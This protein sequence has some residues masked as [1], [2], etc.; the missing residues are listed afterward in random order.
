MHELSIDAEFESLIRPLTTDELE[1]LEESLL[2]DGC[3]DPLV[4]WDEQN[5]LL[6][7]HNRYRIC[8]TNDIEYSIHRIS[9]EDRDAARVWI[10]KNQCARRNISDDQRAMYAVAIYEIRSKLAKSERAEKANEVR[11]GSLEDD[12]SSKEK[13]PKVR[14]QVADEVNISERKL[15]NAIA[16][17]RNRPDLAEKVAAG[18]MKTSKA[19]REMKLEQLTKSLES[20]EAVEAKK[21][22]GVY[23]VVVLDPP[24]QI[25]WLPRPDARPNQVGLEYPLMSDAEIA[26]LELPCADDCHVFV[27]TTHSKLPYTFDLLKKWGLKYVCTFVWH[28]PG[29]FQPIGLPQYNCEFCVYARMG[30]PK[31]VDTKAFS[32]CFDAPRTGQSEKPEAFYDMLRRTTRGRRIDMF[33]RRSIEGF[34]GWGKEAQDA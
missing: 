2:H 22:E 34:E 24:W 11:H 8:T 33:N 1:H 7:G 15:K 31:F 9:L 25:G 27:W 29:G 12:V 26:E 30:T 4:V 32:T 23:D 14:Q 16:L 19:V 17:K 5:I 6:D 10:F 18:E 28:K 21:L 20:V 3:R 13:K